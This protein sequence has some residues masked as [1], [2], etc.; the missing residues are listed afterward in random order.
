[1][2]GAPRKAYNARKVS[3]R[4]G[5]LPP[6]RTPWADLRAD[7]RFRPHPVAPSPP[8]LLLGQKEGLLGAPSLGG[9]PALTR[10]G[11]V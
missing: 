11:V 2:V 8:F 5:G 3:G 7:E 10:L 4:V 1:M 6:G 9:G